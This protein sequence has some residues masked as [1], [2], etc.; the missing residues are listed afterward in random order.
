LWNRT[1]FDIPRATHCQGTVESLLY[2]HR[3]EEAWRVM[4]QAW[5]RFWRGLG[6]RAGMID[7][8]AEQLRARA[9]LAIFSTNADSSAGRVVRQF[10]ARAERSAWTMKQGWG[11]MVGSGLAMTRRDRCTAA[12]KLELAEERFFES[13]LEHVQAACRR[14]RGEAIGGRNGAELIASA[15]AQLRSLGAVNPERMAHR[16][17]PGHCWN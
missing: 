6:Q 10:S 1:E 14:R 11:L 16:I 15:D 13:G 4:C 8:I 5:P 17:V 3:Y 7:L 9:A 2:A 12:T